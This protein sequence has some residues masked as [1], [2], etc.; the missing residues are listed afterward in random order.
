[1]WRTKSLVLE[2]DAE[3][4]F[5]AVSRSLREAD[6]E[7]WVATLYL[8]KFVHGDTDSRSGVVPAGCTCNECSAVRNQEAEWEDRRTK[9]RTALMDEY[10]STMRIEWT[11]ELLASGIAMPDG[12]ITTWGEATIAQHEARLEMLATNVHA[13]ASTAA[14]HQYAIDAIRATQSRSLAEVTAILT[15][16]AVGTP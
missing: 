16:K 8:G 12:S 5:T 9:A 2:R 14:R 13:N 4:D 6:D 10:R 7:A 15:Q 11:P 3:R 1:M